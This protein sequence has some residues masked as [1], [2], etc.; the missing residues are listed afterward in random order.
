MASFLE[1]YGTVTEEAYKHENKT[2][3]VTSLHVMNLL[4]IRPVSAGPSLLQSLPSEN[5]GPLVR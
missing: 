1:C 2:G 4:Q 5:M 3:D